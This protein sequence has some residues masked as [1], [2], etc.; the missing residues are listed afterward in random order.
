ML[1]M[2]RRACEYINS[3]IEEKPIIGMI[4]G[5]GLGYLAD[6]IQ[7]QRVINYKDIPNFPVSTVIGHEGKLVVG[8]LEGV[9]VITLKGRFHAYE[10]HKIRN[11]AFPICNER[12][13]SE[14]AYF[15]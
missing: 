4:L 6:K 15:D 7:D 12:T 2:V 1:T 11:I 8:K 13:W 10:G 5:S 9:Q 3:Q 14:G